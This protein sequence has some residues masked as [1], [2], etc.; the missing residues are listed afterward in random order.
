MTTINDVGILIGLNNAIKV[1]EN[2]EKNLEIR[3]EKL[4]SVN[5][6]LTREDAVNI[7]LNSDA[8]ITVK[9]NGTGCIQRK[10]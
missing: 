5:P 6:N 2:F 3:T 8:C 10:R 9:N 1:L 7:I 4:I